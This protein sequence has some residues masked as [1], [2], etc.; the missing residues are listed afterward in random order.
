MTTTGEVKH[1]FFSWLKEDP[2]EK[3]EFGEFLEVYNIKQEWLARKSNTSQSLISLLTCN[4]DHVPKPKTA[5]KIIKVLQEFEP[6][7]KIDD[8]WSTY[9]SK[10]RSY[11]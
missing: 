5:L 1:M 11:N 2:K 8:L 10:L 9:S 7:L 4:H 6:N 3:T